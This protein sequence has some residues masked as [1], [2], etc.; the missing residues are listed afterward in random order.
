[1]NLILKL[2]ERETELLERISTKM[3]VDYEQKA[4][5]IPIDSLLDIIKDLNVE[6]D[7]AEQKY[8][9]FVDVVNENYRPLTNKEMYGTYD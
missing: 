9:N 8:R 3:G 4:N 2:N 5:E 6:L 7:R 1:M